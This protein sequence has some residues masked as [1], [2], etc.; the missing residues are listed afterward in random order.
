MSGP[1]KEMIQ[2]GERGIYTSSPYKSEIAWRRWTQSC[3]S[4][5]VPAQELRSIRWN[6]EAAGL[7]QISAS[8]FCLMH[9][10][11]HDIAEAKN[12]KM[13]QKVNQTNAWERMQSRALK[14]NYTDTF[15]AEEAPQSQTSP[16]GRAGCRCI[17]TPL[18]SSLTFI[19][20]SYQKTRNT[21]LNRPLPQ[22]VWPF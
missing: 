12:T 22:L 20:L 13:V 7:Q 11:P 10:L 9:V 6:Q 8:S 5:I 4:R 14:I 2:G 21:G 17:A 19:L 18:H 1:E 3:C 15:L 16:P